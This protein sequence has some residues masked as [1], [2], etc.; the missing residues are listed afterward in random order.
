MLVF[1]FCLFFFVLNLQT[2]FKNS[3]VFIY[4]FFIVFSF[5]FSTSKKFHVSFCGTQ[6][7]SCWWC[8]SWQNTSQ[9]W[10]IPMWLDFFYPPSNQY[11]IWGNARGK[12]HEW[13]NIRGKCIV[14]EWKISL[15]VYS[16][17]SLTTACYFWDILENI[18]LVF[19][20]LKSQQRSARTYS[21]FFILIFIL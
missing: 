14:T 11:T 7:K 12:K 15:P 20:P 6:K 17:R 4:L 1:F 16:R 19:S 13:L 5:S 18:F 3:F 8:L 10:T 2:F 21:V 9:V